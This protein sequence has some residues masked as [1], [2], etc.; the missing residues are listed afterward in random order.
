MLLAKD[1][2]LKMGVALINV[3]VPEIAAICLEFVFYPIRIFTETFIENL[4]F[5][6]FCL[7]VC[8]TFL[9]CFCLNVP[10]AQHK[11]AKNNGACNSFSWVTALLFGLSFS[12]RC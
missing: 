11:E 7:H 9:C 3:I 12:Y 10:E 5:V 1:I 2:N 6:A 8:H 4:G